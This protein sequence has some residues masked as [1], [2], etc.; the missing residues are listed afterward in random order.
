[1]SGYF[2]SASYF[3]NSANIVWGVSGGKGVVSCYSHSQQLVFLSF[4]IF[5]ISS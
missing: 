2:V 1:M 5:L 4:M 3:Q